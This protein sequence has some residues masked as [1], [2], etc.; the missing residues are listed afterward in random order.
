MFGPLFKPLKDLWLSSVGG[1]HILSNGEKP[2][3]L[4]LYTSSVK[5]SK[6]CL[7][8]FM[9]GCQ[10]DQLENTQPLHTPSCLNLPHAQLII[11]K[12]T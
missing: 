2:K 10:L 5:V 1:S 7:H 3:N 9:L 4:N 6:F 11:F 12:S 8:Y